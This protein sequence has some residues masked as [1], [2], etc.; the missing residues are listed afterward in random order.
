MSLNFGASMYDYLM[1][2]LILFLAISNAGLL[3]VKFHRRRDFSILGA[4]VSRVFLALIAFYYAGAPEQHP[5]GH[6]GVIVLLASD[7][8]GNIVWLA[9][10]KYRDSIAYTS[11]MTTINYLMGKIAVIVDNPYISYFTIDEQG[12]IEFA[13]PKMKTLFNDPELVG[14]NLY[15][16]LDWDSVERIKNSPA[17]FCDGYVKLGETQLKVKI[18]SA[19]TMNGHRTITGSIMEY[20]IKQC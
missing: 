2:M 17:I 18:N 6:I 5:F 1:D 19:T 15:E 4:V 9:T 16:F 12:I 20:D 8:I 7:L 10:K 14:K 11:Y 3:L 13:N